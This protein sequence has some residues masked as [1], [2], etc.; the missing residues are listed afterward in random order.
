MSHLAL[1]LAIVST[2]P[3][4]LA[5][6]P[7]PTAAV[8][9]QAAPVAAYVPPGAPTTPPT[10][11]LAAKDLSAKFA[12][13]I[14]CEEGRKD[15]N[16][17]YCALTKIGKDPIWTP[18]QPVSYAGLSVLVKTGGDLKKALSD[19][20]TISVLHLGPSSAKL[21]SLGAVT[22]PEQKAMIA[23]LQKVLAGEQKDPPVLPA[24]VTGTWKNDAHGGRTA[25][26]LDRLFA[27]I[28]TAT[29]VRLFRTD[30]L[31]GA[32]YVTVEN[33]A[34]GQRLSV[35]PLSTGIQ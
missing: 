14:K 29:P 22:S 7:A 16:M 18:G 33:Q 32:V 26:K 12:A 5:A 17:H 35:F 20:P 21:L 2:L 13:F 1:A 27:D 9:G 23:T 8:P 34:D 4:A 30:T 10:E 6:T 28:T 15:P 19:Q 11:D 25:L 31:H 24:S 3:A